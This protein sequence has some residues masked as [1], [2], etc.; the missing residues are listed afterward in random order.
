[1]HKIIA[2]ILFY[3]LSN[4]SWAIELDRK[5][6]VENQPPGYCSWA[7]L[8]TL[9]RHN[10]IQP[11]IGL[12]ESRKQEADPVILETDASGKQRYVQMPKHVGSDSILRAKLSQLNVKFRMTETDSKDRSLLIL[13]D[14]IGVVV[15]V[16]QGARGPAA[17]MI[18]LTHYDDKTV[19]FYDCNQPED[20]WEG[21][22]DWFDHWWTGLSIVVEK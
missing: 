7:S 1:M 17:H 19:R 11:L 21:S 16:E 4:I 3:L 20:I 13:A 5:D 18:V 8:E 6:R 22:R 9:G 14:D 10:N 15:G 12:V 2:C